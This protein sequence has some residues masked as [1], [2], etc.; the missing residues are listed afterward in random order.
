MT[1]KVREI[2]SAANPYVKDL[3][4]LQM[5]KRRD[6][7][8][9]FI[10]E[11]GRVVLEALDCGVAPIA[12]VY[13]AAERDAAAV[14]R[15]RA[16]ASREGAE[17]VEVTPDILGKIARKENPQSVIGVFRQ[18]AKPLSSLAAPPEALIVAL[19]GVK[20]PGNLGTIIR[21][22][23]AV[24]GAGVILIGETCDPF[25]MEAVR[26]T[27]GSLF[28]VPLYRATLADFLAF[29]ESWRGDVIGAALQTNV[30]YRT[31]R[32]RRPLIL[33]MGAEQSGLSEEAR[34]ACTC[35]VKMP[36]RGR[37]DSLNLAV[38]TGVMLYK[39]TEEA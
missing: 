29:R 16:R 28:A 39:I 37:A 22:V 3:R 36:M 13:A 8:G 11:G 21:T 31:P 17:L 15:V 7:T 2:A 4:A 18:N 25:S 1:A 9:L 10:A 35:L 38:S 12:L 5:K 14:A 27:M 34:R 6:E 32:Y 24:A 33:L 30:D 20:D 26:A 23:D 19:E